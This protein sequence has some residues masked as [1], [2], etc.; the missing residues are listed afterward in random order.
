M[1]KDPETLSFDYKLLQIPLPWYHRVSSDVTLLCV[2]PI[3][4]LHRAKR[5]LN[6]GLNILVR[7]GRWQMCCLKS[8]VSSM[9]SHWSYD[10]Y[11][12]TFS[13]WSRQTNWTVVL[14]TPIQMV[15]LVCV[16]N[17]SVCSL[18]SDYVLWKHMSTPVLLVLLRV[19]SPSF[20]DWTPIDL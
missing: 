19:H 15:V 13:R 18:D 9:S 10:E 16:W 2:S 3:V 14:H 11:K 17:Y 8:F 20:H 5:V 6:K 1:Y 4:H 12:N 7:T